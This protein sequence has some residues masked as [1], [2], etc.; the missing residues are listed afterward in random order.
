MELKAQQINILQKIGWLIL[1]PILKFFTDYKLEAESDIKNLTRPM[2]IVSNHVSFLD[3]SI[4]GTILPI[5]SKVYPLY[6][7][8]KDTVITTP[9]LG[10][11]LKLFG[12]FRAFKGEGLEK[13][14]E[15]PKRILQ[16]GYSVSFFPQGRRY[17][18]FKVEQGRP[19]TAAL[20]LATNKPILPIAICGLNPFSWKNFFLRKY[21][22]K[23]KI[24][25]P[26]LLKEEI[27]SAILTDLLRP[28]QII[29]EEIE[30]LL[31]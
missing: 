9:L 25:Q 19:G 20:A 29:M 11:F 23:V 22:V 10:G 30:K 1:R 26:F 8:T 5:N 17:G 6:F 28:T 4:I 27:T 16:A 13:S 12:A 7:I 31:K 18:E 2:I 21:R 24:G 14:L 15:E 3:P